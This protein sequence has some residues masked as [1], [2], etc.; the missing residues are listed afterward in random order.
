MIK[1]NPELK[2]I[3]IAPELDI[4]F[5]E[6]LLHNIWKKF[7]DKRSPFPLSFPL[8]E[9]TGLNFLGGRVLIETNGWTIHPEDHECFVNSIIDPA[10][11][12]FVTLKK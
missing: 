3:T 4:L 7:F 5:L 12:E 10:T 9:D 1:V 8:K 2:T 11:N 6:E